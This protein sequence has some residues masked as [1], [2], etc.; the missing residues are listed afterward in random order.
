MAVLSYFVRWSRYS[1]SGQI[2]YFLSYAPFRLILLFFLVGSVEVNFTTFGGFSRKG[3]FSSVF[4][5]FV[6]SVEVV[7]TSIGVTEILLETAAG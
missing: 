3:H 6:S 5:G 7:V 2:S 1:R 4:V